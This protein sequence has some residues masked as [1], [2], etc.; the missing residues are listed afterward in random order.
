[1]E[2]LLANY[3]SEDEE[4]QGNEEEEEASPPS[5]SA[6]PKPLFRPLPQQQHNNPSSASSF[7]SSLPLPKS[8]SG[9]SSSSIFSSLPP[10][11]SQPS[12]SLIPSSAD[13]VPKKVV[14]FRPPIN[15]SL[16]RN[17][18]N[19]DDD[20]E[21][22]EPEK[23]TKEIAS[24]TQAASSKSLSSILPAPRNSFGLAPARKSIIEP[25]PAPAAG[26]ASDVNRVSSGNGPYQ[27]IRDYGS[28][29]TAAPPSGMG[30]GSSSGNYASYGSFQGNL[31][32]GSLSEGG[33]NY[34]DY[35][36]LQAPVDG[37]SGFGNE[38]YGNFVNHGAHDGNFIE[39]S[40]GASSENYGA[41]ANYGS[42]EGSWVDG[43]TPAMGSGPSPAS[44]RIGR[45]MG[46]RGRDEIPADIVEVKQEELMSN[47]P[48]EDQVK[49]TGIAFGPSYQ[50]VSS[51]KGKPSKLH[52]RK[53][54]IGSLYFDM[55]QKEME[56]TERR[57]RGLLTKSETQAKY[58]W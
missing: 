19:I 12:K 1:M 39:G 28:R 18:S 30:N 3:G 7:F 57:A 54:Q 15:P 42:Y 33:G 20:D 58:G 56:L 27:D 31:V 37:S 5:K 44:E 4:E 32:D 21:D 51:A 23:S 36:N 41:N 17:Q 8:A 55:K 50:P 49:L 22:D 45:M 40:F 16:F 34:T 6:P 53:H 46:K 29:S 25:T 52:K 2:S 14:A 26:V 35:G 9:F 10:P 11:K 13:P 47:R 48:R 24:S 43:S 38:N